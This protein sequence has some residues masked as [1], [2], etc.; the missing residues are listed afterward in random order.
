MRVRSGGS[1]S[2]ATAGVAAVIVIVLAMPAGCHKPEPPPVAYTGETL[3][4]TVL[5]VK[6]VPPD[7]SSFILMEPARSQGRFPAAIALSRLE[8][9]Q[10]YFSA[11]YKGGPTRQRWWAGDIDWEE[12]MQ[13]NSLCNTI[14]QVREMIV[15]DSKSP[16]VP[17]T[18][19]PDLVESA[20]RL[21]ASLCLVYGPSPA[22]PSYAGLWG[23]ILD[24]QT[25]NQVAFVQAQAGP[26]DFQPSQPDRRKG[27]LRR[28]DVN[29]LAYRK[30]QEQTR[31]CIMALIAK[32]T[33]PITTQPSPWKDDDPRLKL[34]LIPTR[35]TT[36]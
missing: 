15:M 12:R 34:Y 18:T 8:P 6:Q 29:Y 19:L 30:F 4:S 3:A 28:C 13:W 26:E 7:P 24:T 11:D 33:A 16:V 36:W 17:E 31:Q 10:D 14:P 22:E 21:R 1:L 2:R 9:P 5:G 35:A 27:D 32:D 23:I 25:G 20:R